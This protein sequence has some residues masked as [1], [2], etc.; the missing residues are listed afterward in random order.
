MKIQFKFVIL[1]LL[2][3]NILSANDSFSFP[4]YFEFN[5]YALDTNEAKSIQNFFRLFD[6]YKIDSI[7]I[8]GFCD[9]IGKSKFN[10]K[11]SKY[12]ALSVLEVLKSKFDSIPITAF[13]SIPLDTSL[14]KSEQRI[15]N[16]RTSILLYYSKLDTTK[17]KKTSNALKKEDY[18]Q[19]LKE[20]KVGQKLKTSILFEG[21]SSQILKSSLDEID[22]LYQALNNSK[23]KVE[24]Q[25][26]I[27]CTPINAGDGEDFATGKKNLSEE[28]A[29]KIYETLILRKID[30]SRLRYKGFAATQP[31][32]KG[33]EADR[34]VEIEIIE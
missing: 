9:D 25:G 19:F 4:V 18:V 34:R 20:G 29:R 13:G 11:L 27:C 17:I 22:Y 23:V 30:S 33:D 3:T 10:I 24:L 8:H 6:K 1:F 28:R 26:H 7:A 2:Q 32:G 31:T 15:K 12:R 16:R 14:D 21:C 5:S